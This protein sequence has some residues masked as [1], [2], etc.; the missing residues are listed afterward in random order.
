MSVR[1]H[2]FSI[3]SYLDNTLASTPKPRA[4]YN[5]I[6]PSISCSP[7]ATTSFHFFF[8]NEV[9]CFEWSML[10]S[11]DASLVL[12]CDKACS[13]RPPTRYS[14]THHWTNSR[15]NGVVVVVEEEEEARWRSPYDLVSSMDS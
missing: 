11:M 10:T 3:F 1:D 7:L 2:H 13:N 4:V 14:S 12:P 5:I 15:K 6:P 9:G 8:N